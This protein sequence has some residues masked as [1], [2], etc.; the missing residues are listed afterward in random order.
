MKN[1]YAAITRRLNDPAFA[2]QV[3]KCM[4]IGFSCSLS[5]NG[6][7]G[8]II[9]YEVTHRPS[10]K[11][12]YHDSFGKPRELIVTDQ[13]Y[14]SDAEINR[15][16]ADKV[17]SLYTMNWLDYAGHLDH[18]SRDFTVAAWNSWG[19]AF[20]DPG[21]IDFIKSK[22]V[23]LTASLKSAALI[24][25]EGKNRQGD[26][27]WHVSFPMYLRWVNA[28][29]EKTDI[30][31][32]KITISRTNDPLHPDGLIISELNAPRATNGSE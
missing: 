19:S 26:Y 20:R 25:E 21:N 31:S 22:Q 27:E 4:M 13:A 24:V 12:V 1:T 2:R 29:G 10:V 6:L 32:V 7:L 14:F 9:A 3:I 8:F 28:S 5:V 30:L 16:A 18:A 11:Y 15:W 17:T 23:I